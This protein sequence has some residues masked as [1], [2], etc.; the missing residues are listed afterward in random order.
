MQ[1]HFFPLSTVKIPVREFSLQVVLWWVRKVVCH[2]WDVLEGLE[3]NPIDEASALEW[4]QENSNN[5]SVQLSTV[6]LI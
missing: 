4:S 6:P 5:Y 3:L 1:S 2:K